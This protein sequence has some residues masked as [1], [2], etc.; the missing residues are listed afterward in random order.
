M[1]SKTEIAQYVVK[2]LVAAKVDVVVTEQIAS[3][4]NYNEDD[5]GVK[6]VGGAVGYVASCKAQP[7]TDAA[8]VKTIAWIKAKKEAR[9]NK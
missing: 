1:I 9:N 6:I 5:R 2:T 4:T 7:Y 3:H 8:V